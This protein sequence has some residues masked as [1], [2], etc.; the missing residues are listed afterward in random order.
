LKVN[1]N[2]FSKENPMS[3]K[4]AAIV[5][6]IAAVV[7]WILNYFSQLTMDT[8]RTDPSAFVL[9]AVKTYLVAWAG[10]FMTLAGLE[11]LVHRGDTERNL[12]ESKNLPST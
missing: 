7:I 8:I 4:D 3:L 5:A 9:D 12:K 6:T 1:F 10:N 11:Q 2:P